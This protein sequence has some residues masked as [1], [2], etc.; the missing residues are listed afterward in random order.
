MRALRRP[1]RCAGPA[2][3]LCY[4]GTVHLVGL[5]LVNV[6]PFGDRTIPF[7]DER[8]NPR[9]VVVIHGAPGTGKSLLLSAIA[10]TRPGHVSV[11]QRRGP[12][13]GIRPHV[14]ADWL[15]HQEDPERPHPLRLVSPNARPE[16]EGEALRRKE[17]QLFDRRAHEGGFVVVGIPAH[18]FFSRQPVSIAAPQRSVLRYDL[19][20]AAALA[21]STRFDLTRA[22]KTT[23]AYAEIAG[24]LAERDG[25]PRTTPDPA[26]LRQGLRRAL[27][28]VLP[29]VGLAFEGVDPTTLEPRFSTDSGHLLPF[30]DL[31]AQAKNLVA[32][33][34]LP[35]QA[36]FAGRDGADPRASEAVV[37]VD[38]LEA[39]LGPTLEA[40]VLDLLERALP[41]VQ[42]IVS[43][44]SVRVAA[45][46]GAG[47][48]VAL[49]HDPADR[50]V[51]VALGTEAMT[52]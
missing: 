12:L 48:V 28:V 30:D 36:I 51:E 10:H 19:R 5:R 15:L 31:P 41:A 25:G 20:G 32:L 46:R 39:H 1:G 37:L 14:V 21:D 2:P 42:W 33:V 47:E 3:T 52:H 18:R 8:A 27:E 4:D 11:P 34:T 13:H 40:T 43:T 23:L 29:A 6:G 44:A 26:V 49:R 16:G 45:S 7:A 17:Q 35:A 22:T 24:S 9:P 38:D 50:T